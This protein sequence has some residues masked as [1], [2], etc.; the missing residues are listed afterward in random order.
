[1]PKSAL[2]SPQ[3]ALAG[4]LGL[5]SLY[6]GAALLLEARPAHPPPPLPALIPD[7]N[8]SPAAELQLLPGIGPARA[9]AIVAER[10]RG[11]PFAGLPALERVAGIGPMTVAGLKG[12]A[13]AAGRGP[14]PP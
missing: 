4:A 10:E 11:G 12:R 14:P 6:Q 2:L 1:M 9:A 13:T 3:I 5:V 7:V 8:T